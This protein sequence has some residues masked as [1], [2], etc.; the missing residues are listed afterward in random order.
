MPVTDNRVC[1]NRVCDNRV[2]DNRA[3]MA[4]RVCD[5]RVCDDRV[6]DNERSFAVLVRLDLFSPLRALMAPINGVP[7]VRLDFL[8]RSPLTSEYEVPCSCDRALM[9]YRVCDN[10]VCDNRVCDNRALMAY[11]SH[12]G[13][14]TTSRL[15][16]ILGLFCRI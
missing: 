3:L 12:C 5:N 2:C 13:V 9:A 1:D 11:P 7:G 10:R 14:P 16:K 4:Y 15:L 8:T 6:C